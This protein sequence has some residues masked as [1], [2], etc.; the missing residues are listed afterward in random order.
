MQKSKGSNEEFSKLFHE[1]QMKIKKTRIQRN[2]IKEIKRFN[3]ACE[4]IIKQIK[5]ISN[6]EEETDLGVEMNKE[7]DEVEDTNDDYEE[8]EEE[9]TEN[10]CE[11]ED[12]EE[13]IEDNY[14]MM[15]WGY[16]DRSEIAYT[17]K[18]VKLI[19]VKIK[20]SNEHRKEHIQKKKEEDEEEK[21]SKKI[22]IV[23]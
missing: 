2:K 6:K 14:E 3:E 20:G 7:G 22:K 4:N 12:E 19:E 9:D 18:Y 5:G 13:N 23:K 16:K 15:L 10:D 8:D 1:I 11:E 21:G 17:N